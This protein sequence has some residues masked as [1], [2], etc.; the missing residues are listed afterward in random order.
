MKYESYPPRLVGACHDL[1]SFQCCAML[2]DIAADVA[3]FEALHPQDTAVAWTRAAGNAACK[4]KVC[5]TRQPHMGKAEAYCGGDGITGAYVVPSGE[6]IPEVMG[7][8][9]AGLLVEQ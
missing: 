4:G 6:P 2:D 9:V 3:V 7:R 1:S 8:M 5:A